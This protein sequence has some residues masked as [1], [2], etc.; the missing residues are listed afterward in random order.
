MNDAGRSDV[1]VAEAGRIRTITVL[2]C[3]HNRAG[4]LDRALRSID[5]ADTPSGWRVEVLVMANACTDETHAVLDEYAGG[6]RPFKFS[7]RWAPEP[8]PGKSNALNTAIALL[9]DGIVAFV[10]DD[11]RVAPGYLSAICRA[12][13]THR[14][15]SMF[16]GRIYPDWDGS[17]PEWVHDE[18][19]FRI[20]PLPV[21]RS[22]SGPVQMEITAERRLPGGGNLA[23]RT[24]VFQR[25]G[26]FAADLGPHGHD[27][28][29]GED[30]EFLMRAR[31]AG[32]RLIYTPEMVQYHYA[33]PDRLKTGY[34]LRKAY[35]RSRTSTEAPPG[36]PGVPL[37]MLRK[38]L[39]YA[40]Q[41]ALAFD[42]TKRLHFAIRLA[43]TLG[44]IRAAAASR[45]DASGPAAERA[46][47]S[48]IILATLAGLLVIIAL[49]VPV[50]AMP[51]MRAELVA[52]V[53]T[54]VP[55]AATLVLKALRDYSQTGPRIPA[56]VRQKFRGYALRVVLLQGAMAYAL[57]LLLGAPGVAVLSAWA[58]MLDA[59]PGLAAMMLAALASMLTL[60]LLQFCRHLLHLPASIV[61]SSHYRMSRFYRIWCLLTPARIKVAETL[62]GGAVSGTCLVGTSELLARGRTDWLLPL[63]A[64]A[65]IYLC[66]GWWARRPQPAAT[67]ASAIL[68]HGERPNI[69]MLGADT[70]RADRLDGSYARRL[71]PTLDA[72]A[73]RGTL[74]ANCYVPCARTAPSLISLLTGAWPHQHGVRDNYV[75]DAE[76]RLAV[77]TLPAILRR[78]GY[79]TAAISDWCG[80]DMGKFS[81]GFEYVDVPPDQWNIRYL[82]RQ[83]P[84]DLRLLLSLFARNPAGRA[85]LPEIYAL[86][87]VPTTD[88]LGRDCRDL[89]TYLAGQSRPFLLNAFFST[90]HGPFGS[91]YPYYTRFAEPGYR[92]ESKFA[93][94]RVSDPFEI[95][96]R[97]GEPRTEFDL[98]QIINLYDGCV[99]RF[100]DEVARIVAHLD[101]LGIADSTIVVIY[102]DH[103]MDFFEAGTWGQGNS[104]L[105]DTSSR[106]PLL[107]A[108]PRRPGQ[109]LRRD[110]VR[111]IDL[112]PTLLELTGTTATRPT[113]GQTLVPLLDGGSD[114]APRSAYTETGVWLTDLP[115]T[116]AGHLRYPPLLDL[117]DVV[118][119][120]SG[121]ISIKREH[122]RHVIESKD[123][124]I[125]KGRWKLTYQPLVN[126]PLL[127]L[128]DVEADPAHR[129]DLS[130][131]EPVVAAALWRELQFMLEQDPALQGSFGHEKSPAAVQ[132][133]RTATAT[134]LNET[135]GTPP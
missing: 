25:I 94:A 114:P 30:T 109:N 68:R 59:T 35:H 37:Y 84:K 86:G 101:E 24:G 70:L 26:G 135:A 102:S 44:E 77:D 47:R 41:S 113:E 48:A 19:P 126:G 129:H 85:L 38:A 49:T 50:G 93:M 117:L 61:A 64:F 39:Q 98:D 58:A 8:Q 23:L 55:L 130:Q 89:I 133:A 75:E 110:I 28:G 14:D 54:A 2:I 5:S 105:G 87:G 91:E 120:D 82:L 73:A 16:C 13:D 118:D 46:R 36:K 103:G 66:L 65:A 56:H 128:F 99:A 15:F 21:P 69:L 18:G 27:L 124:M 71:T 132:E 60:V 32:E 63:A 104:V 76:T 3:T 20:R 10:D 95:I 115:G 134:A 123:R 112:L 121:T 81:F 111:N 11:H 12:A 57:L 88:A 4:L 90:T 6:Q 34:L 62:I 72:L 122:A 40:G 74:F 80:A 29:G 96:R 31:Q 97:Q 17:E 127:K 131:R 106:T 53:M 78:N 83:G 100:D 67:T 45:V 9:A 51:A 1:Q 92:G 42:P 116:P 7:L 107:V 22:D 108:D 33:D 119:L 43:A 52:L 125:R 79:M